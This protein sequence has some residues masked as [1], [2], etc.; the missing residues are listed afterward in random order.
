VDFFD[1]AREAQPIVFLWVLGLSF[2]LLLVVFRS[3]VIPLTSILMNLLSVA[4]AYGIL[5]LVFQGGEDSEPLF[6]F[7]AQVDAIEA[8][9]PL[10]LFAVLFGLS[11]DYQIFLL[12]RVK[13][14]WDKSG[15]TTEAV[16][17]GLRTT[18]SI[19][20]GAA[21]IMVAVFM[22]FALGSL[23]AFQQMGLGLAVAVFVDAFVVRTILVPSTMRLLGHANW[24]LP[25]FLR[26]MPKLDFEAPATRHVPVP[27]EIDE[28]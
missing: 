11:M 13:E 24:Y 4:A 16:A 20:T 19:I 18:G 9:L 6:G 28:R 8:W 1:D 22:G 14:H 21:L 15:N 23:P 3:L 17:H 25:R 2:L 12:S 5:V 7:F 27:V 10:M 26:W